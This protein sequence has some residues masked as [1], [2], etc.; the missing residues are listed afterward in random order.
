MNAQERFAADLAAAVPAKSRPVLIVRRGRCGCRVAAVHNVGGRLVLVGTRQ[1]LVE[2]GP[3]THRQVEVVPFLV[4]DLD[5]PEAPEARGCQHSSGELLD[6]AA[7][8]LAA[9]TTTR[10]GS[11]FLV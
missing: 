1:N 7:I 9:R 2:T 4:P 6:L 8:A 3:G 10:R 5:H 11:T